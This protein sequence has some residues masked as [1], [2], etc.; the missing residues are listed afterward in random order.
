L[1]TGGG[2]VILKKGE[3][4]F[5]LPE[6]VETYGSQLGLYS[7]GD[8]E[9]NPQSVLYMVVQIG[10]HE[11][12][13]LTKGKRE[14][15]GTPTFYATNHCEEVDEILLWPVPIGDIHAVFTYQPARKQ[16]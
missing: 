12:V 15:R 4:T 14:V 16:I 9:K 1:F 2:I 5:T 10:L 7:D 6:R 8:P 3:L 11:F 13:K